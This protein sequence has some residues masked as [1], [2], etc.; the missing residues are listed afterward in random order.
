MPIQ[1]R[2][3]SPKSPILAKIPRAC[4]DDLT[5][6]EFFEEQRWGSTPC[7]VR[8]GDTDVSQ[9]R[10]ADGGRHAR[11]LWRCRGCKRQFTVRVGT[12][13]EDS[14]V[15]LRHWAYAFWA[16]CQSK[17]G[18]SAM[19]ISRATNVTYKTALF[20]MHRIRWAM[21]PAN[22]TEPQLGGD[23]SVVEYDETY[24]GGKP[25]GVTFRDNGR[26]RLGP[27]PDFKDRKTP[28]VAGV[29]RGGRV[30][31]KVVADVT[32]STLKQHVREMVHPN[33]TLMT[34]DRK[35]YKGLDAEYRGGHYRINHSRGKYVD[36]EVYTNTIEGF[37]ALLK[38]G[39]VG[40]YHSV[41]KKHLHRYVSEAEFKYNTRRED[42]GERV[43]RAIRGA[44]G[45]RLTYR[46]QT[47]GGEP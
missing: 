47:R 21:Q 14:P 13:M 7:C 33:A 12:I 2:A 20:M 37:F 9:V 17:K 8:C 28:V 4:S 32:P 35:G 31:A 30:K 27:A 5:A 34:D 41:S 29:E 22:E 40:T 39:M 44:D 24:V 26:V 42:D 38:R 46:Q 43:S 23:G 3:G 45:R 6:V 1:R 25:R 10:A 11:Y 18:V 16:A 19:E 36:G 15:P